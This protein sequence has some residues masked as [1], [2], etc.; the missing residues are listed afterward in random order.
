[1]LRISPSTTE[2]IGCSSTNCSHGIALHLLQAQRNPA[3]A[4]VHVQDHHVHFLAG[5]D[6]LAR[7]DV[8]LGPGHLGDVHQAFH[9]RLQLHEGAVVGD[10]GDAAGEL[11]ADRILGGHAFPRIGFQL[12]HAEADALGLR[13]EA[14]DLHLDLLADLQ[15]L[16]RVVDAAPG[17]VGDVQQPVHAAQIDEGAVIG[18]VLHHAVEDLAFLQALDQ[19]AALLGAGLFQHGAAGHHDVAA[20]AVHLQDLERLRRA[21]QRADVAHRADIDLA[22]GQEGHGAAEIDGEAALHPAVDAAG[23]ALLALERLFQVAPGFLA[24]SL[25]A[26]QHDGA[27]LVL[28]ALDIEFD[29]VARLDVRLGAGRAEFLQGDA[30]FGFQADIDDGVFVGEA[31]D[32]A[33]DDRTV[34]AG[35]AAQGLIEERGEVFAVEMVLRRGLG[36]R[37][38]AGGGGCC[39]VVGMFRYGCPGAGPEVAVGLRVFPAG[40]QGGETRLARDRQPRAGLRRSGR[41]TRSSGAMSPTHTPGGGR[42]KAATPCPAVPIL[43]GDRRVSP[44]ISAGQGRPAAFFRCPCQAKRWVAGLRRS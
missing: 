32:P 38:G 31:E 7:M 40:M 37:D 3:L 11:G 25:L 42:V 20:G 19:L 13:V 18:D 9:P 8:L 16:G 36:R 17:D 24:A 30:A 4:G 41:G 35:I 39:H 14:D 21:H 22:A 28:V 2:P 29:E 44:R 33:G 1:M 34:E 10:V 23:D 15:R 12:L 43:P 26:R 5:R 27:V 6:D